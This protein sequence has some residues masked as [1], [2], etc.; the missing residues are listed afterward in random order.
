MEELEDIDALINDVVLVGSAEKRENGRTAAQ[1]KVKTFANNFANIGNIGEEQRKTEEKKVS[2]TILRKDGGEMN[3]HICPPSPSPSPSPPPSV[4]R[5]KAAKRSSTNGNRLASGSPMKRRRAETSMSEQMENGTAKNGLVGEEKTKDAFHKSFLF[6]PNDVQLTPKERVDVTFEVKE[7]REVN[8]GVEV[9]SC[10]SFS[11]D[12]T[13][14]SAAEQ[15]QLVRCCLIDAKPSQTVLGGRVIAAFTNTQNCGSLQL[16]KGMKIGVCRFQLPKFD[17]VS[18]PM[19]DPCANRREEMLGVNTG[20]CIDSAAC[21]AATRETQPDSALTQAATEEKSG[22]L[23]ENK[24]IGGIHADTSLLQKVQDI[25]PDS[26]GMRPVKAGCDTGLILE[27]SSNVLTGGELINGLDGVSTTS[28]HLKEDSGNDATEQAKCVDGAKPVKVCPENL[29]PPP[30][31]SLTA[32]PP[33]LHLNTHNQDRHSSTEETEEKKFDIKKEDLKDV[34]SSDLFLENIRAG[35]TALEYLD[36]EICGFVELY[37]AWCHA[38]G[39]APTSEEGDELLQQVKSYQSPSCI[40]SGK[41]YHQNEPHRCF[42]CN[43]L[44]R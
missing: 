34:K 24:K 44:F 27:S 40:T 29:L 10:F 9:K 39:N 23:N 6:F 14:L 1:I 8:V 32:L 38:E 41:G 11:Y 12:R 16:A 26:I 7:L 17:K 25:V 42:F 35:M 18:A 33:H 13:L 43:S 28:W 36:P 21:T 30:Q 20:N 19:G 22:A 3:G 4:S 37:F 2:Q 5:Q 31:S 15:Q